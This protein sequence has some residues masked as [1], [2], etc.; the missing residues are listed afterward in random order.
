MGT[1][2]SILTSLLS[3]LWVRSQQDV[4]FRRRSRMGSSLA[5][6]ATWADSWATVSYIFL[7]WLVLSKEVA[8]GKTA[9]T[10]RKSSPFPPL[11]LDLF[12]AWI[13]DSGLCS[14]C[15]LSSGT[16]PGG[17]L[18]GLVGQT[19]LVSPCVSSLQQPMVS[20]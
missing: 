19:S 11:S 6:L 18:A 2:D 13:C 15:W 16:L 14:V 9:L 1:S 7:L 3:L 12:C 17:R 20:F 8:L 10:N 5:L 4:V